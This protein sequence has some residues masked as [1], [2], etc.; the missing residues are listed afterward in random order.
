MAARPPRRYAEGTTVD[1]R[2]SQGES[3]GILAQHGV[4]RQGW[5]Q[6]PEGDELHFELQGHLFRFRIVR[7][8]MDEI[9]R[10]YPNAYDPQA[11]LDAEG[12]WEAA[13]S[14]CSWCGSPTGPPCW[15]ANNDVAARRAHRPPERPINPASEYLDSE[16]DW[17]PEWG[18]YPRQKPPRD[19]GTRGKGGRT[20]RGG[21]PHREGL[22]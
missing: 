9:R 20:P 15:Y 3:A 18:A 19:P 5:M 1:A 11:K 21:V 22:P 16:R 8:T 6:G 7:P 4:T 13:G 14:F 10:L 17:P 12:R 2:K